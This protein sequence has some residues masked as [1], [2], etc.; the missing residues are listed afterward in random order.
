[1]LDMSVQHRVYLAERLLLEPPTDVM[2]SMLPL[3][4]YFPTTVARDAAVKKIPELLNV[5]TATIE[6]KEPN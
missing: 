4:L 3:I 6:T 1:L 5:N 2:R